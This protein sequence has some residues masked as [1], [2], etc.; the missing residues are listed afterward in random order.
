[1]PSASAPK[2]RESTMRIKK[3]IARSASE[4]R[5][6]IKTDLN[7]FF[8][9][10]F[11]LMYVYG[12]NGKILS[13]LIFFCWHIMVKIGVIYIMKIEVY[14]IKSEKNIF[15]KVRLNDTFDTIAKKF[16]VPVDYVKDNNKGELYFG[17]VLFLPAT[18]FKIHIVKPFETLSK[19]ANIYGVKIAEI[20]KNNNLPSEYIFVGQ[21]LYI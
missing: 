19:I 15:Y 9:V 13:F 10:N 6:I 11:S 4:N 14:D 5:V 18:N 21:K 8:M 12:E 2:T 1:M 20:I 16:D 7:K 3:P 17:K